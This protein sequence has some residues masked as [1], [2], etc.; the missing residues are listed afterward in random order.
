MYLLDSDILVFLSRGKVSIQ[1]KMV[2]AGLTNCVLSEISLAEMYVGVYKNNSKKQEAIVAF[3]EETFSVIP[4]TPVIKTFSKLRAN[5]ELQGTRLEDFD[6]LIG[7]TALANDYI[8]VTHNTK[9][10]S[11]I[12]GLKLEDWVE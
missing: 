11:R 8:L 6:L 3:L 9:H 1:E 12:P 10:F 4:I 5:L 2:R 7:A